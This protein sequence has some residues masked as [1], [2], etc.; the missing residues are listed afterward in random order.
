VTARLREWLR[1]LRDGYR[2]TLKAPETEEPLDLVV[3]RPLAYLWVRLLERTTVTPNQ[4]T[5]A[6]IIVGLGAGWLLG[7]GTSASLRWGAVAVVVFNVLDCV[8]GMLARVRGMRC[9]Y[10]YVLDGLAGY[11]GTL[12]ILLGL[13][14]AVVIRHGDPAAWWAIAFVAGVSMAWWC[15]VV[16][17]LRLEW[18]RRVYGRRQDRAAEL[19][20]LT[21]T[22]AIWR[23]EGTH[24]AQRLLVACY[25]L[26]ARL[27]EGRSAR[28]RLAPAPEDAVPVAEWAAG[29]RPLLRLAVL[30]GPSMQ[31]TGVAVAAACLRP[32]W[33]LLGALFVGNAWGAGVFVARFVVR[34]RLL[35]VPFEEV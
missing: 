23:R 7:L 21:E 10:G 5:L 13:G 31:L 12:A 17:G 9:P 29:Y 22:A 3:Y 25:A 32:E 20:E 34:R 4:V 33:L 2:Q 6:S 19:A 8:D 26:Y 1:S 28:E 35:A 15:A 11:L 30:A 24:R 27:W 14:R 18:M 16:D